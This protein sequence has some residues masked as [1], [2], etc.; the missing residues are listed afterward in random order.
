MSFR[1]W[2]GTF[3][4]STLHWPLFNPFFFFFYRFDFGKIN[5]VAGKKD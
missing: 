1:R 2:T 5:W 3:S 4:F